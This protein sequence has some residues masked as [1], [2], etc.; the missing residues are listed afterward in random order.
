VPDLR[1]AGGL[2][3]RGAGVTHPGRDGEAPHAA[4]LRVGPGELV[5]LTGESGAGKTSLLA[6]VLGAAPLATGTITISGGGTEVDL[7][8]LDR[9][10][11]RRT[12]AWVDQAPFLFA[13][14]VAGNV[15]LAD[16]AASD[17]EVRD[18]LDA[19]GLGAMGLDRPVGESGRGLSAGERRRV[20]LARALLRDA[21]L[22]LLDEP[23]AGLDHEAE[24]VVLEAIR[25]L[26]ERSAVLMAAHRPAAIAVA[27][28]VVV[29]E[30]TA[31][32]AA[33]RVGTGR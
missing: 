13:G 11:W 22:V 27:D 23:T 7:T 14:T 3:I 16:P 25:R 5:A 8:E 15:R 10:A 1:A 19:M 20:A 33:A 6:A 24:A 28:R 29:L 18:A 32:P 2:E 4:S 12:L 26:A 30:A 17:R 9:T 21:P 31:L